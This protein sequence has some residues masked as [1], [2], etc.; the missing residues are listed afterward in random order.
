VFECCTNVFF[1]S[2]FFF[3][4]VNEVFI[5]IVLAIERAEGGGTPEKPGG[6]S[7]S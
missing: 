4:T 5:Q 3:Q 7:V 2:F 6:C 1:N